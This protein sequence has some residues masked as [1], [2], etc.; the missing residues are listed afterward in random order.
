[1]I[2][3]PEGISPFC[4]MVI[5]QHDDEDFIVETTELCIDE[6]PPEMLLTLIPRDGRSPE[7]IDDP[8]YYMDTFRKLKAN[9][10]DVPFELP[11]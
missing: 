2:E 9:G 11:E 8:Q 3:L 6:K 1:M 4:G 5:H 10:W 7:D